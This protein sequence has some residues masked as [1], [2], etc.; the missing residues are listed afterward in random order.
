MADGAVLRGVRTRDRGDDVG[1]GVLVIGVRRQ[2][3]AHDHVHPR[4]AVFDQSRPERLP[5]RVLRAVQ[6]PDA[7][8]FQKILQCLPRKLVRILERLDQPLLFEL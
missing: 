2:V 4:V 5:R 8:G 3:A 1:R 6:I 7:A